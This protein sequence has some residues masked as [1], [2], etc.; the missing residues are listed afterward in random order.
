MKSSILWGISLR[1]TLKVNQHF[2]VLRHF[3]LQGPRISQAE[4]SDCYLLH[5]GLLIGFMLRPSRWKRV[6]PPKC[7]LTFNGQNGVLSHKTN[8]RVAPFVETNWES[9]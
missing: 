4:F 7:Q 1:S 8:F 3:H 9:P 6:L 5:A 2:G